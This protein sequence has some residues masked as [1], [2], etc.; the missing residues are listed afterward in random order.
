M[1]T[2]RL[3]VEFERERTAEACCCASAD[4]WSDAT[5]A[6]LDG[7]LR[8]LRADRSPVTV[9]LTD[10]DH[11]DSH[12]LEVLLEAEA[13]ARARRA[14]VEVIG[15]RESLRLRRSPLEEVRRRRGQYS[16][17]ARQ[18][19]KTRPDRR[20]P[21]RRARASRRGPPSSHMRRVATIVIVAS[22]I[23]A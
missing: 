1:G 16:R 7:V 20:A 19:L 3:A 4:G 12:G 11:I 10:V 14:S 15:V 18:T 13:D 6:L 8:A 9:D 22:A 23:A 21:G 17:Y 2:E 5:A